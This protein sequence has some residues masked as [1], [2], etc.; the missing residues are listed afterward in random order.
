MC[1]HVG[2][3]LG[4]KMQTKEVTWTEVDV[5]WRLIRY[6]PTRR[7]DVAE[8]HTTRPWYSNCAPWNPGDIQGSREHI[9]FIIQIVNIILIISIAFVSFLRPESASLLYW[10]Y[11]KIHISSQGFHRHWEIGDGLPRITHGRRLIWIAATLFRGFSQF[12][13]E[14]F[15]DVTVIRPRSLPYRSFP[16]H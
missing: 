10:G 12:P 14:K 16:T 7:T 8:I 15:P 6:R 2:Y 11:A 13:P 1:K 4:L 3:S 5:P 9:S